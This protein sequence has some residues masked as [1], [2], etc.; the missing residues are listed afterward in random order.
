VLLSL[1]TAVEEPWLKEIF[2]DDY[3]EAA[4]VTYDEAMR[5]VVSRRERRFRDLVLEAK[6]SS[7]DAPLNEAAALL[8]KE[9]LAGRIKLEAWDDTVEQWICA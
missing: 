8:T 6:V 4:G 7:D 5:R 3:R 2:P 1:A 9:V